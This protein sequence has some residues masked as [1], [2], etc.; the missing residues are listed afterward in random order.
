MTHRQTERMITMTSALLTEVTKI[1]VLA[2]SILCSCNLDNS[3]INTTCRLSL[4]HAYIIDTD[5]QSQYRTYNIDCWAWRTDDIDAW[6]CRR[7]CRS[8]FRTKSIISAHY[9]HGQYG[10]NQPHEIHQRIVMGR[11]FYVRRYSCKINKW[12]WWWWCS[13]AAAVAHIA[14]CDAV[15]PSLCPSPPSLIKWKCSRPIPASE[16]TQ[17]FR[18]RVS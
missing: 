17:F 2:T 11:H 4:T 5:W 14:A 8:L 7:V 6:I 10:W 3:S 16:M 1:P 12:W 15:R 9:I 18:Y 13:Y